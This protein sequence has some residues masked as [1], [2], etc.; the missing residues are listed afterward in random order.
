MMVMSGYDFLKSQILVLTNNCCE[1]VTHAVALHFAD[2]TD[3]AY[4]I[5]GVLLYS[6]YFHR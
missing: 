4:C 1:L 6:R 2:R 5:I 3:V